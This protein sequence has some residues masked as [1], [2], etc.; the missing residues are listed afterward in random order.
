MHAM[1]FYEIDQKELDVYIKQA[2]KEK[3]Q[4]DK[5]SPVQA[6][7]HVVRDWTNEGLKERDEAFPCILETLSELSARRAGSSS[8]AKV[9]LPGSGLGRLGHEVASL[10]SNTLCL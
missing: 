7:K 4:A 9:L 10:G 6:L 5:A 3:R 2:E 8:F 1:D